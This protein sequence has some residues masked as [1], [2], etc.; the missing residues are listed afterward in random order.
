ME[1]FEDQNLKCMYDTKNVD[2]FKGER[3]NKL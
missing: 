3:K 1:K 2:N